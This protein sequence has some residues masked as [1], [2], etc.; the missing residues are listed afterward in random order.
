MKMRKIA[1]IGCGSM[2][3][4]MISGIIA[5]NYVQAD[6]ITIMNKNNHERRMEMVDKYGIRATTDYHQLLQDASIIVLAVKPQHIFEALSAA[7]PFINKKKLILSVAA[8][9]TT[10]TIEDIIGEA[11]PIVRS[12]PNTSAA[13]GKSATAMSMNSHTSERQIKTA[14]ELLETFGNAIIV[15]E[16]QL[17][18][19]TGLSGSGPAYIYYLVEAMEEAAAKI[20]LDQTSAKA[21][22]VQT[23]SGAAE[24]LQQSPKSPATLRK[25]VTSPGGTTEAGLQVLQAHKVN[26]AIMDCIIAAS[27]KSKQLGKKLTAEAK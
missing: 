17:D 19:V 10:H 9:I 11:I 26:E 3:E 22:I 8:G 20:G 16:A 24:M 7:K 4:A 27:E 25:E 13:V 18:S 1:F 12:M 2:A 21:L 23:L 14:K 5:N 15:E 6:Q